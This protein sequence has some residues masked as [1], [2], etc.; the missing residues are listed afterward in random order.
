M[1]RDEERF[2]LFH[3]ITV[4]RSTSDAWRALTPYTQ[5]TCGFLSL[6]MESCLHNH[7]TG[8][9]EKQEPGLALFLTPETTRLCFQTRVLKDVGVNSDE[10][11]RECIT[12]YVPRVLHTLHLNTHCLL[13]SLSGALVVGGV[14]TLAH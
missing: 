5:Q 9:C 8:L 14:A 12:H 1:D 13:R 4:K 3:S 10:L 2:L 7:G 6:E 11:T